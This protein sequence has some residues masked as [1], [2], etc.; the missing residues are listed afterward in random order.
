M[1]GRRVAE[2]QAAGRAWREGSKDARP[3]SARKRQ[4]G[5]DRR[6]ALRSDVGGVRALKHAGGDP[7]RPTRRRSSCRSTGST[8]ATRS[9][10]T[11]PTGR[12]T[13]GTFPPQR[14]IA[15]G[16]RPRVRA[17]SEDHVPGAARRR[18]CAEDLGAGRRRCSTSF[19]N[20]P[21][22]SARA[23][24]NWAGSRARRADFFDRYQ[25]RIMFGT[26]AVPNAGNE[27]AAAD[28][29]R[30]SSTS[31]LPLPRDR[32]RILRLRPGAGAAAGALA[33]LRHRAARRDP[34][35]G[36]S[37][38]RDSDFALVNVRALRLR[39]QPA[40]CGPLEGLGSLRLECG[41]RPDEAF[42][43]HP[44]EI[45]PQGIERILLPARPR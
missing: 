21:S 24:A 33:D 16:A 27:Y 41:T 43:R 2:V 19:H 13:A 40:A 9:C 44:R 12:S 42:D 11:I 1:A 5:Q 38:K 17:A 39:Q 35:Q 10:S 23:S 14:E 20:R 30:P 32:G 28:L 29:R 34:A 15:G 31:L 7:R 3:V 37:R 26:D 25:D 8:S 22:R 45:Q 4:A 6:P 36:V 18:I